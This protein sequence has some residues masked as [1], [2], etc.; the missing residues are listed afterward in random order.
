LTKLNHEKLRHLPR[1]TLGT[2][3]L[4]APLDLIPVRPLD[5]LQPHMPFKKW[6]MRCEVEFLYM[7]AEER[8]PLVRCCHDCRLDT[9]DEA[10]LN[11]L[12]PRLP[13][14]VLVESI[15]GIAAAEKR[16]ADHGCR[17]AKAREAGSRGEADRHRRRMVS[18]SVEKAII[19]NRHGV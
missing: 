14:D 18:A 6:C 10:R 3:P 11:G 9:E 19:L 8:P 1:A 13:D 16:I 5:R 15:R 17:A 2:G 7:G 12:D 4:A